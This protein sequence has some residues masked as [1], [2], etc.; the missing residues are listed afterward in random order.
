[1]DEAGPERSVIAREELVFLAEVIAELPPKYRRAFLL[2][3]VDDE[4]F[5]EIG[6]KMRLKERM[7]RRYV[8]NALLYLRLRREGVTA[9]KAW[10]QLQS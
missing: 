9:Q 10:Q 2:H 8:T 4:S 7:V 1:L 5:Q 6:L 3:R